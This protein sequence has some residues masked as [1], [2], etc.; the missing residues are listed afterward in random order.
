MIWCTAE[1]DAAPDQVP[2]LSRA[3]H[4]GQV[5]A[6]VG[7]RSGAQHPLPRCTWLSHPLQSGSLAT[8]P[9]NLPQKLP[10]PGCCLIFSSSHKTGA[11]DGRQQRPYK[12]DQSCVWSLQ[13]WVPSPVPSRPC[14]GRA[15]LQEDLELQ[16]T[17][18]SVLQEGERQGVQQQQ[19]GLSSNAS[20]VGWEGP[21]SQLKNSL[22]KREQ[23]HCHGHLEAGDCIAFSASLPNIWGCK[24]KASRAVG[25]L[26]PQVIDTWAV[27]V[28]FA[29]IGFP[30][31]SRDGI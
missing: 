31:A 11:C 9:D 15:R 28:F 27:K 25:P 14:T 13:P 19:W 8:T 30:A 23:N 2:P 26:L 22:A 10:F 29:C 1:S 24:V 7:Y 12:G 16:S 4:M 6:S 3:G 18:V 21:H 20:A 5:F 17:P